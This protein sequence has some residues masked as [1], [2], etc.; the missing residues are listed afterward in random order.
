MWKIRATDTY[1]VYLLFSEIF[2]KIVTAHTGVYSATRLGRTK[3]AA[4]PQVIAILYFHNL[5]CSNLT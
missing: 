1:I 2:R 5:T 4:Q 3:M